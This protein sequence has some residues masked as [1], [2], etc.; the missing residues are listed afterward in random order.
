MSPRLSRFAPAFGAALAVLASAAALIGAAA[1]VYQ[2]D[3][4]GPGPQRPPQ[5]KTL[6]EF[7][8]RYDS[9]S[10]KKCHEKIYGQWEKS[11]HATPLIGYKG[12]LFI[13]KH[14]P[15]ADPERVTRQTYPCFKCHLPHIK[16][17]SRAVIVEIARAFK[18]KDKKT[19]ARLG[20]TCI[21]CHHDLAV[22]HTRPAPGVIY[23]NQNLAEHDHP[24]FKRVV[25]SPILK[26]P[27]QCGQCH[28]QGPNLEFT[29]PIQCGTLY[30]SYLH[31]YVPSGGTRTCQDCHM[32]RG[33]HSWPPNFT[34]PASVSARLRKSVGL[35][36]RVLAYRSQVLTPG[37]P[38]PQVVIEAKITSRAGHR[39]PDG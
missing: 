5:A 20:I 9:S 2:V 29:P 27:V 18:M 26:D 28:G 39:L 38:Y 16:N 22:V 35:E 10:C 33:D 17:A 11:H 3:A 31:A 1:P 7:I 36:V 23:G 25:K 6:A 12:D 4:F 13:A 19:L 30:G 34:R 15:V 21:V 8:R 37:R 14:V 24:V 32:P